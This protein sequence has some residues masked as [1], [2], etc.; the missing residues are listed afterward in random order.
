MMKFLER[1]VGVVLTFL[2]LSVV[3]FVWE[4]SLMQI[5]QD[6]VLNGMAKLGYTVAADPTGDL[7][8]TSNNTSDL[9]SS[10]Y[11]WR[12]LWVGRNANIE[13]T[14]NITTLNAPTGRGATFV[15]AASDASVKSKAQADYVVVGNADDEIQLAISAL[16]VVGGTVLLSEGTFGISA[17]IILSSDI[18][19]R[20]SGREITRLVASANG[21][22]G[23]LRATTKSNI[24][25]RDFSLD[26]VKASYND[27]YGTWLD[28]ITGL[29]ID[30]VGCYRCAL[31]GIF[32]HGLTG[33]TEYFQITNCYSEGNGHR[34]IIADPRVQFGVIA[35][36]ILYNNGYS[37]INV[38]HG[39]S[40]ITIANNVIDTTGSNNG[41]NVSNTVDRLSIIGNTINATA[42][43]GIFL[44]SNVYEVSII[45]NTIKSCS[46]SAIR[47]HGAVQDGAYGWQVEGDTARIIISG[48]S[49]G[50]NGQDG[51][52]LSNDGGSY[53]AK[54]VIVT[55]NQIVGNTH[56]GYREVGSTSYNTVSD[57]QFALNGDG[58]V[59]LQST[60]NLVNNNIGYVTENSGKAT[61]LINTGAIVVSHGLAT[62]PTRVMA[63]MTSNPG[64]AVSTY[65]SSDNSTSFTINTSSN[66]TS[67]TTFD[68]RAWIG[69]G[70]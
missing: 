4:N 36:N 18:T 45:G 14:A 59:L 23:I 20:G 57:N 2:L 67:A 26:G 68:W 65:I 22:H 9:G 5:N 32:V 34:G 10:S 54:R 1:L 6:T 46:E 27:N 12:D 60:T 37:G 44:G 19:L 41:I 64:L 63:T 53:Q 70:N 62:T 3:L 11:N 24:T 15:V 48:N 31:Q 17:N 25:I 43:S 69:E 30:N 28:N 13:G 58:E 29:L 39:A 50:S 66:V 35:N 47:I 40:D 56:Y 61:M 49:L 55:S 33:Y 52:Y 16:P 7:L 51:V 38:G 42:Q 8:P 21:L